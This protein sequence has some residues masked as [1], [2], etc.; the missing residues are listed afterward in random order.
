MRE[1]F[2]QIPS[3][4]QRQILFRLIAGFTSLLLFFVILMSF[5]DVYFSLPCLILAAFLIVNGSLLF[6]NCSKGRYIIVQ[7]V[8]S[9]IETKG[10]R[11]KVKAFY[12]EF[13]EMVLKIPVR[14]RIRHLHTGNTVTVYLSSKTPVYEK[15]NIL[16]IC[17]YHAIDIQKEV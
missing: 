15:D 12:M 13:E 4:L 8:C 10:F 7:G 5:S 14:Q 1:K 11:K 2:K 3:A 6:Y 17:S 16:F 9:D